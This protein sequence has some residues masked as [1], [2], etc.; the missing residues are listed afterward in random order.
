MGAPRGEP[1]PP[2]SGRDPAPD[3]RAHPARRSQAQD[4]AP[5]R[6]RSR[7]LDLPVLRAR[8]RQPHR[9]PRDPAVEGRLVLVG[10]HRHLLR[11]MQPAQGRPAPE[12]GEHGARPHSRAP[13]A[14][15][16]SS[17]WPRRRSPRRGSST[18]WLPDGAGPSAAGKRGRPVLPTRH[19]APPAAPPTPGAAARG[20]GTR[21]VSV[22]SP[23][24][25]APRFPPRPR[26]H[27][28]HARR[29]RLRN[30][31]PTAPT[32]PVRLGSR[33]PWPLPALPP[34]PAQPAAAPRGRRPRPTDRPD[35]QPSDDRPATAGDI[36]SLRRWL[37]MTAI[38]AVAATVI[39]VLAY[40]AANDNDA[41]RI[42]PTRGPSPAPSSGA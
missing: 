11:A 20:A 36:R 32:R 38:W 15:R 19:P 13:P 10:Q 1:Q 41:Q 35:R 26:P 6:L 37:A 17:T 18:W 29:A 8:A 28:R 7:S 14:R 16:C 30:S 21:R 2:P 42:A 12:P 31:Q 39:A 22:R 34:P 4:H 9:G 33:R 25:G 3:L 24:T 23:G 27:P 5:G 40:L